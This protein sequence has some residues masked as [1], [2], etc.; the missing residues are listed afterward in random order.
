V[1]QGRQV[2]IDGGQGKLTRERN[3]ARTIGEEKAD[4]CEQRIKFSLQNQKKPLGGGGGT[5]GGACDQKDVTGKTLSETFPL[6]RLEI[7]RSPGI[8]RGPRKSSYGN[9]DTEKRKRS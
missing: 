8:R 4:S 3:S 1:V 7:K 6:S 2:G 5:G 9:G